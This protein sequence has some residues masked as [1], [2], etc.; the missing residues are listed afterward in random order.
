MIDSLEKNETKDK[1][2]HER[3]GRERERR[4]GGDGLNVADCEGDCAD[5][6]HQQQKHCCFA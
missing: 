5:Y 4:R 6:G 1:L 2:K 3:K